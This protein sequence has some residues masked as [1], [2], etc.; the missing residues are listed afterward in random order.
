[1]LA[2]A[3]LGEDERLIDTARGGAMFSP[4]PSRATSDGGAWDH[5]P[6]SRIESD[7]ETRSDV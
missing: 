1:L 3:Y 7:R 5:P 2:D 4:E 6:M